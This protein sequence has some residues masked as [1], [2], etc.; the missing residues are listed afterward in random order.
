MTPDLEKFR[1]RRFVE[2]LNEMGEVE[3]VDKNTNLSDVSGIIQNC[4]KAVW[5]KNAGPEATEL[6]ANVNGSRKRLAIAM[7]VKEEQL[8][9]EYQRRLE[10]PQPIIE[11]E[12][13]AAPA[14]EV[15]LKG[16]Q[17]NLALLGNHLQ[18]K[19]EYTI[20]TRRETVKYNLK[21]AML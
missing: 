21:D 10:N 12:K 3:I 17:I 5:F 16:E 2:K 1:L 20:L 4:P 9:S 8:L 19:L 13:S 18:V 6:V 11:I 14:Q 7:G 15:V